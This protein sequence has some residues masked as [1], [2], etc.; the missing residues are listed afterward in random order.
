MRLL[1]LFA[2][3]MVNFSS[4]AQD[5]NNWIRTYGGGGYDIGVVG[6]ETEDREYI[7]A[8]STSSSGSGNSDIKLMKL[9]SLGNEL[10]IKVFGSTGVD[11]V[12]SLCVSNDKGFLIAGYSN[13]FGN[14]GYDF[15]IFKTDYAG[16]L[17]WEKTFG[18]SDWDFAESIYETADGNILVVGTT[19]SYGN[20]DSDIYLLK[21]NS[22]GD[23]LWDKTFGGNKTEKGYAVIE[24]YD[25]NILIVGQTNSFSDSYRAYMIKADN[26][27][28]VIWAKMY[29]DRENAVFYDI[30]ETGDY[31]YVACGSSKNPDY[32]VTD[33]YITKVDNGGSEIWKIEDYQPANDEF[34]SIVV[35]NGHEYALAGYTESHG[36]GGRDVYVGIYPLIDPMFHTTFGGTDL[37]EAYHISL[38]TDGGFLI[39]GTTKSFTPGIQSVFINK[40]DSIRFFKFDPIIV[41]IK[42]EKNKEEFTFLPYPNPFTRKTFINLPENYQKIDLKVFSIDGKNI[43]NYFN[44]QHKN[45]QLIITN[46]NDMKGLFFFQVFENGMFLA[47]GKLITTSN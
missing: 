7:I 40:T 13:G 16:N 1:F 47:K 9:D 44:F 11:V 5:P 17:I 36:L 15:Y 27:G 25:E 18:G 28:E 6:Y 22:I 34:F 26:K 29:S 43:S 21:L 30:K 14:G 32:G 37:D 4:S 10:W 38:T 19:F 45:N 12:K 39:T 20:G 3:F 42:E 23:K 8:A 24:S 33:F 41:N 31:G 2:I 35:K 46:N